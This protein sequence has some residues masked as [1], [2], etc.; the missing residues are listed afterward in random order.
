MVKRS[1]SRSVH[2]DASGMMIDLMFLMLLTL[3]S[4]YVTEES[5]LTDDQEGNVN[6]VRTITLVSDAMTAIDAQWDGGPD[7]LAGRPAGMRD[8]GLAWSTEYSTDRQ[9]KVISIF[10]FGPLEGGELR[11]SCSE[12]C[13]FEASPLKGGGVGRLSAPGAILAVSSAHLAIRE[14]GGR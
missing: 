2:A 7:F 8:E 10:F 5:R 4:V 12:A 14:G 3:L 13:R 6:D 11:I 9:T 1:R